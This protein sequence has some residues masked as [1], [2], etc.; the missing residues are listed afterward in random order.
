VPDSVN[1][2][3]GAV[4]V[5]VGAAVPPAVPVVAVLVV[6]VAVLGVVAVLVVFA[7]HSRWWS[8]GGRGRGG[9]GDRHG[10]RGGPAA[11]KQRAG[12]Q[13]G[14]E[15]RNRLGGGRAHHTDGIRPRSQRSSQARTTALCDIAHASLD[16][17]LVA[18]NL[19]R[20]L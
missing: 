2:G 3:S 10:L 5:V 1:A 12:A 9:F 17:L 19:R 18:A 20:V 6:V 11:A 16:I 8:M 13:A 4:R 14:R 7:G 15:H